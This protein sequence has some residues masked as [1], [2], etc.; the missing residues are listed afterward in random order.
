MIDD[1]TILRKISDG[2]EGIV[3]ETESSGSNF[4]VKVFHSSEEFDIEV[5]NY[6]KIPTHPNLF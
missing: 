5:N 2:H 1:M 3:Y 6:S 4:A